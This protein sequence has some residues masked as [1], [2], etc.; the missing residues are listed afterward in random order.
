LIFFI[1]SREGY[2][3]KVGG[4]RGI[5]CRVTGNIC[6]STTRS[7]DENKKMKKVRECVT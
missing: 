3:E 7:G 5:C 6:V 4:E 2:T 1:A